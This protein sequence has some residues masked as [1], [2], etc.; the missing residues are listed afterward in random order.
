MDV[1]ALQLR[2]WQPIETRDRSPQQH[3]I[4]IP[5]AVM[6][7]DNTRSVKGIHMSKAASVCGLSGVCVRVCRK[8]AEVCGGLSAVRWLKTGGLLPPAA[9]DT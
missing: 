4:G 3:M 5:T 7:A 1:L 2:G 6:L 9:Q 8:M